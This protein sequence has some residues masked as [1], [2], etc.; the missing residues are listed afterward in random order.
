MAAARGR[1]RRGDL[2]VVAM[3]SGYW[4]GEVS[5]VTGA[6]DVSLWRPGGE[7]A[8]PPGP[9]RGI[10]LDPAAAAGVYVVPGGLIEVRGAL[11]TAAV[12]TLPGS[13]TAGM[14]YRTPG[15]LCAA[16]R[17]HLRSSPVAEFL[18]RAALQREAAIEAAARAAAAHAAG[19]DG[20][21][22]GAAF[23]AAVAAANSCYRQALALATRGPGRNPARGRG[24]GVRPGSGRDAARPDLE[25]GP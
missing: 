19:P 11:A 21:Q 5:G 23:R 17:P 4:P 25:P 7:A 20:E 22:A 12:H 15:G 13:A 6:G 1:A 16:L 24:G 8:G 10:R 9:P 3:T 18:R 2:V 14:P